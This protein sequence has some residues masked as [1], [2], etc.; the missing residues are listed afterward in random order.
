MKKGKGRV[1]NACFIIMGANYLFGA[2]FLQRRFG[3][4][5]RRG[6]EERTCRAA[7]G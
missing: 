5:E 1:V 3:L 4:G 7:G 2:D 6:R